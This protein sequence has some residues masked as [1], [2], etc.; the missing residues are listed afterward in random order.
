MSVTFRATRAG[1]S[2]KLP[3]LAGSYTKGAIWK[4]RKKKGPGESHAGAKRT[5]NKAGS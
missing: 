3:R 1:K 4:A 5:T 2:A